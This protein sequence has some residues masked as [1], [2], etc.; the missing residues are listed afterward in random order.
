MILAGADAKIQ[1][2]FKAFHFTPRKHHSR[3]S[4]D[5]DVGAAAIAE[6]DENTGQRNLLPLPLTEKFHSLFSIVQ[7]I[8]QQVVSLA[9]PPPVQIQ[10]THLFLRYAVLRI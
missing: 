9:I 1:H 6:T 8:I 5:E 10:H 4:K 7:R 3:R 2:F